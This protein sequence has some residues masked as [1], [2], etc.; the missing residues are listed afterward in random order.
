MRTFN[1]KVRNIQD[2]KYLTYVMGEETELDE[3]VLDYCEEN[4]VKELIGIIYEEDE[5]YDYLTYDIT[6]KISLDDFIKTKVSCEQV[7]SVIRNVA[8]GLVSLKEQTIPLTYILLN[9]SFIYV[10]EDALDIQFICLPVESKG[11]L[12]T[13][14][15]GF[16]RQLI[17]NMQFDVEEDLNYVGKL[18][19]YING[20]SF[21]LRDLI[22][23]CEA[24]MEEADVAYEDVSTIDADGVE[25]VKSSSEDTVSGIMNSLGQSDEPLPE[26]GDDEEDEEDEE[27]VIPEGISAIKLD[28]EDDIP[29]VKEETKPAEEDSTVKEE[30][31]SAEED[32]VAEEETKSV[33]ADNVAEEKTE[34]SNT[35]EVPAA[36]EEFVKP[37]K[38]TKLSIA[39]DNDDI[40]GI[41]EFEN[42]ATSGILLGG[43][44]TTH[45]KETDIDVIKNRIKELVGEV[46]NA[47]ESIEYETSSK[48]I[49]DTD[50]F[51]K[52]KKNVVKV[53]RAAIIQNVEAGI[54]K[55]E[56]TH[57][58][59]ATENVSEDA[60]T[61]NIAV[62]VVEDVKPET[63]EESKPAAT[64]AG[65]A[66]TA[67]M[68]SIK[69]V[70]KAAPYLV[71]VN[72]EERV[73]IMKVPFKIGKA[74]RGVDYTVRDNSAISRQHAI[75]IEK[76]DV[77]YI[78]D[79]KSTNHTYVNGKM[80]ED[81]EEVM[82]TH[83]SLITLGDE[84]FIFKI[85]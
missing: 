38:K 46:P 71:R 4:E 44:G 16:V 7:L 25:V 24:L 47:K 56:S 55:E 82:L 50:P 29:A 53:N 45:K 75:I 70:P 43:T 62:P 77:C 60:P 28:E 13:E 41:N 52:N 85:R 31:K 3:D 33:E 11:S 27:E 14:F 37:S 8:N 22:G 58:A 84:E 61:E 74:T 68:N 69:N 19:T 32:N 63:V 26:I 65:I 12:A 6:N 17:A 18:I 81:G 35:E 80:V 79:N 10:D 21:T 1:F 51:S 49:K 54:E 30:V 73:M 20:D 42:N 2:E 64:V 67:V 72:N 76:D 9:R 57:E 34:A 83:D 5:D 48:N 78:K 39:Q 36:E 15:K 40:L 23:L 66:D 59:E